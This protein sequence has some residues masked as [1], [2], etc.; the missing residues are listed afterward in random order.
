MTRTL[1]HGQMVI[2]CA[3]RHAPLEMKPAGFY[4]LK[5]AGA[6]MTIIAFKCEVCHRTLYVTEEVPQSKPAAVDI[7]SLDQTP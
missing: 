1:E 2:E 6:A 5:E 4:A 3:Q 7:E